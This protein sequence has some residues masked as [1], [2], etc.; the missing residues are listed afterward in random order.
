[1]LFL[2]EHCPW[3]LGGLLLGFVVIG[4]QW[5]A[6]LPIGMTGA[7]GSWL[8]WLKKPS[9]S[10]P[11]RIF[12]F[13]GVAAGAFAYSRLIG[14]EATFAHGSFD[15]RISDSLWIK[16]IVLSLAGIL[17]GFGTRLSGGCTSGHGLCGMSRGSSSGL[18]ATATFFATAAIVAQLVVLLGGI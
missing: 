18:A 4:L 9:Q 8:E 15:Q 16:G 17:I 13:L 1:M 11:W 10:V 6:N 12:F 5:L 2:V 7:F 14:F 3:W